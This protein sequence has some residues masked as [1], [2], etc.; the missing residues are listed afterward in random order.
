M[1]SWAR[2]PGLRP[3]DA[4]AL[5]HA[6]GVRG[7]SELI[8]T[9]LQRHCDC[10]PLVTGIVAGLVNDYFPDRGNFN[11][12][13]ADPDHGGSLNIAELGLVEKR[14]HILRAAIETLPDA[15]LQLLATLALLTEAADYDTLAAH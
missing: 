4:E 7:D 10:H 1:L 6:C 3:A 14:N 12:W 8:Q 15:S 9:Y 2:L 5:L 11:A 13:A